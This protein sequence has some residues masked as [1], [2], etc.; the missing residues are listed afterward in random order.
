MDKE[1]FGELNDQ[2]FDMAMSKL[3]IKLREKER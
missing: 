1:N 3:G 2:K